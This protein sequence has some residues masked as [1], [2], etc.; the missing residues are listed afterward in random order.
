V[1][2]RHTHTTAAFYPLTATPWQFPS[3][4]RIKKRKKKKKNT[5]SV[6]VRRE[7]KRSAE[8]SQPD[9]S[10]WTHLVLCSASGPAYSWTLSLSLSLL[11][12]VP[13]GSSSGSKHTLCFVFL[14]TP[15][16][17][18]LPPCERPLGF[19]DPSPRFRIRADLA[20]RPPAAALPLRSGS[21]PGNSRSAAGPGAALASASRGEL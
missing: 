5:A 11:P 7:R 1:A 16:S 15:V 2:K 4:S 12:S 19:R 13:V 20:L 10:A 21:T 3:S 8:A 18:I 17:L 9:S 14:A 6:R